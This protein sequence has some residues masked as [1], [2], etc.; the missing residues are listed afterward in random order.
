MICIRNYI[1]KL[2]ITER[3]PDIYEK[4]FTENW[5]IWL[6]RAVYIVTQALAATNTMQ[7]SLPSLAAVMPNEPN[8]TSLRVQGIFQADSGIANSL[9]GL[10]NPKSTKSL[11]NNKTIINSHDLISSA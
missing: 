10:P 7:R 9:I 11:N 6:S 1:S 5:K 2:K 3:A 4:P 8:P